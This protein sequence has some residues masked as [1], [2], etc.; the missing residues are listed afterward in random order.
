MSK[1][2]VVLDDNASKFTGTS[3]EGKSKSVVAAMKERERQLYDKQVKAVMEK[4][5][6]EIEKEVKEAE[7]DEAKKKYGPILDKWAYDLGGAKKNIRTL[8][9]T[10]GEWCCCHADAHGDVGGVEFHSDFNLAD[11]DAGQGEDVLSEG[12][13]CEDEENMSCRKC[14]RTRW[15][16]AL[17][18]RS[19]SQVESSMR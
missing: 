16:E 14:I 19:T 3:Y 9:T 17:R 10:V 11:P 12:D 6:R 4:R 5:E 15:L 18:S 13:A 7:R 1:E 8:L 2:D